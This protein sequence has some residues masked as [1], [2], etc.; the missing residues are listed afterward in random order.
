MA[1]DP[2][3]RATSDRSARPNSDIQPAGVP[4][5][6]PVTAGLPAR[7]SHPVL[8]KPVDGATPA[9]A[10][11]DPAAAFGVH[12]VAHELEVS[13]PSDSVESE[14][15]AAA[16]AMVAGAPVAVGRASPQIA[17]AEYHEVYG[18]QDPEVLDGSGFGAEQWRKQI[19]KGGKY[20][21]PALQ[22][23]SKSGGTPLDGVELDD[24]ELLDVLQHAQGEAGM[25][26]LMGAE[27]TAE[28]GVSEA[29]L[30]EYLA[31]SNQALRVM[32]IDTVESY[33]MFIAHAAGETAMSVM[34]EG[35]T[36]KYEDTPEIN[37]T[38]PGGPIQ[39]ANP[40]HTGRGTIDPEKR[41]GNVAGQ[42]WDRTFIGRGPIQV[43]HDYNYV[44]TI[45]YLEERAVQLRA[46]D[47]EADAALCQEAADAVK[48]DPKAAADP[49]YAF[50]FSAS[51]MQH[52]G[53]A[54][55]SAGFGKEVTSQQ[56]G[57]KFT[58]GHKDKQSPKKEAAY[59]R[60]HQILSGKI[61]SRPDISA[62]PDRGF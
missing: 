50:L 44:R 45:A 25:T 53:M 17:R 11:P 21:P 3:R 38:D 14:A 24:G 9:L 58:G 46:E 12:L 37:G 43:T 20:D 16:D 41:G 60:A 34:T 28:R 40:N 4:G 36:N 48:Q 57:A 56:L 19:G 26:S 31:Q 42:D 10:R 15:E 1:F 5:K 30:Q 54:K 39:Y 49:K 51:L 18:S 2:I 29:K 6:R 52:T 7:A 23:A 62:A 35:Q 32:G 22:A 8:R 47:N 13:K 55:Q 59:K 61:A 33:A 27:K